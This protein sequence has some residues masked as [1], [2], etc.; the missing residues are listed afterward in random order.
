MESVL[1]WG[2]YF[3]P[4]YH[5]PGGT[6]HNQRKVRLNRPQWEKYP[7]IPSPSKKFI[8]NPF[9]IAKKIETEPPSLLDFI[10]LRTLE[11]VTPSHEKQE[12]PVGI[13]FFILSQQISSMV[14]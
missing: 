10:Q 7:E 13:W 1:W 5:R 8:K 11:F 2:L 6:S 9:L 14:K 12:N 4:L 3:T